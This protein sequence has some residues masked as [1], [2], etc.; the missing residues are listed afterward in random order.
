MRSVAR[1]ARRTREGRGGEA[2]ALSMRGGVD[3]ASETR[4]AVTTAW[5]FIADT[6][7][8]VSTSRFGSVACDDSTHGAD[9]GQQP[10][11]AAS[12][13]VCGL[14][15]ACGSHS[16][17]ATHTGAAAAS[18]ATTSSAMAVPRSMGVTS[19][20][21]VQK[22]LFPSLTGDTWR[23]DG[24]HR[25]A[26]CGASVEAVGTERQRSCRL[27]ATD[28]RPMSTGTSTSGPITAA[29]AAP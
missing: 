17:I 15:H 19:E 7:G 18:A 1:C 27:S 11:A 8:T 10:S 28:T 24:C 22:G 3:D 21:I 26:A 29:N 4:T 20:P 23:G 2:G 6:R 12:I 16:P 5:N 25:L 9:G 13:F 14:Q